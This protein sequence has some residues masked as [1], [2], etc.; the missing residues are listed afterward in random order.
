MDFLNPPNQNLIKSG[1]ILVDLSSFKNGFYKD[2]K[3]YRQDIWE[4]IQYRESLVKWPSVNE[5]IRMG[6]NHATILMDNRK[7]GS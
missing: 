6:M 3:G 7:G 5:K 2:E 4:Y 1:D